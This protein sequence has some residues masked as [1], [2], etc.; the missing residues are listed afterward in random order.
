M[1]FSLFL[2]IM[3]MLHSLKV[4]NQYLCLRPITFEA[5]C[6]ELERKNIY[7]T[8]QN[9]DNIVWFPLALACE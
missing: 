2:L 9:Q 4:M 5:E 1:P 6:F 7:F 8:M 3:V